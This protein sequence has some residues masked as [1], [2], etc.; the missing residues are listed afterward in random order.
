M[1]T[2]RLVRSSG[3]GRQVLDALIE[4][5][6]SRGVRELMLH[7]QTTAQNFYLRAGFAPYGAVFE[8]AGIPHI[9][10]RRSI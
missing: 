3:V 5:A 7:A 2:S 10:M 9:E 6:R 1:A 8:E 4:A